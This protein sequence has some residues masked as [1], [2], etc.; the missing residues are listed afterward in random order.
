M[1]A[2]AVDRHRTGFRE[3]ASWPVVTVTLQEVDLSGNSTQRKE[4]DM[5]SNQDSSKQ[6]SSSSSQKDEDPGS[7][8]RGFAGMPEEKQRE[9]ASQGGRAAHE[10]GMAHEFDSDEASRA[11]QKGGQVA[12][13]KGTAHEF[14]SDEASR[15][16]QKGGKAVSQDREH[17]SEIGRKGGESRQSA[18]D[19]DAESSQQSTSGK[20]SGQRK[21]G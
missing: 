18:N 4:F 8:K 13:E 9:I 20:P 19:E 17:M 1:N 6:K 12:H 14:D 16:G 3:S 15:A 5:A 11:G 10:K 7:S 21:R 2:G